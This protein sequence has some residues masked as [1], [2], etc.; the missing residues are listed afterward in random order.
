MSVQHGLA[1][2]GVKTKI[3]VPFEQMLKELDTHFIVYVP[4][5]GMGNLKSRT[6]ETV[7]FLTERVGGTTRVSGVGTWIDESGKVI[8]DD[9]AK[10]E[11]FTTPGKWKDERQALL[12]YLQNKKTQ[13]DQDILAIEFEEDM[14][15]V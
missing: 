15:W 12:R 11:V 6:D 5:T 1:A 8:P 14:F 4:S 2:K 10:I 9:V 3:D 7:S 13:W